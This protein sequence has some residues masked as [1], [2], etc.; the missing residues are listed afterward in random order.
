MYNMCSK[1]TVEHKEVGQQVRSSSSSSTLK[2]FKGLGAA[3][4]LT[5]A[6]IPTRSSTKVERR[7]DT[8]QQANSSSRGGYV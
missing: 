2:L 1:K 4:P 3:A 5:T 6:R 8:E 7:E